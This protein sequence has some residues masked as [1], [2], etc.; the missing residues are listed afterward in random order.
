MSNYS[1][2]G[3]N[4]HEAVET[5]HVIRRRREMESVHSALSPAARSLSGDLT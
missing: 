1:L 4:K 2:S 3:R 5:L